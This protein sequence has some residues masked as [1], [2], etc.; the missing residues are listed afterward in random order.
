M[1]P[2][3]LARR[4]SN[5]TLKESPDGTINEAYANQCNENPTRPWVCWPMNTKQIPTMLM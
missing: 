5:L 4:E 2:F 1:T 3:L